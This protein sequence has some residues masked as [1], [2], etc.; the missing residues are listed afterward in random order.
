MSPPRA[1]LAATAHQTTGPFFPEQYIRPEDSDLAHGA[2]P[3]AG[4]RLLLSGRVTD[5]LGK[6][7]V[8]VILEIWQADAQGRY[9]APGFRGWGRTWTD[10][11]GRYRFLTIKPG[12]HAVP[13]S[14]RHRAPHIT[15][16]LLGSGLMRPLVTQVYFPGEALNAHD[17]QLALIRGRARARLIATPSSDPLAP[18]G[19]A[20]LDFDIRLSGR[21]E[22]PFLED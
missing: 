13:E 2:A 4:E 15:V 21:N 9:G 14:N 1:K 3:I 6:P 16:T 10:R 22:T 12:G 18:P 8:N 11:D 17:P 7:A 19:V 20:T 5:G